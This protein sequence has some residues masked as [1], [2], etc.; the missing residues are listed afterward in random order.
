ME[1]IGNQFFN[2]LQKRELGRQACLRAGCTHFMSMDT[3]EFYLEDQLRR[4]MEEVERG[5]WDAT[6]CRM[7]ILFK[8]AVYEYW[9]PDEMN[10]VPL[11]CRC[12]PE[13]PLRLAEPYPV[14]LDPTRRVANA[15]R[16]ALLPRELVEMYHMSFVR[17][18]MALKL[19]NTS[20][21]A[22]LEHAR[23]FLARFATWRPEDGPIHPHPVIGRL[24]TEIRRLPNHFGVDLDLLCA[25]CCASGRLWRCAR[26][27]SARYCSR[28]CQRAHW[29]VHKAHPSLF[30]SLSPL[31]LLTQCAAR[32]PREEP[33]P[34]RRRNLT[35][36]RNRQKPIGRLALTRTLPPPRARRRHPRR[37]RGY[38]Y[39]RTARGSRHT[40]GA[41]ESATSR[42]RRGGPAGAGA[43]DG[44]KGK[45]GA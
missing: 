6:A 34:N 30:D 20:N 28:R 8:E 19:Q 33:T 36:W 23:E 39:Y 40:G 24:F 42:R 27:Q 35:T 2:E 32:M 31:H 21:R 5:Q 18:H 45:T 26:C 12:R 14:L 16:F 15:P 44:R 41:S 22:N 1:A 4:A 43:A 3:D 10:A 38:L 13:S 9:P 25:L 7:R 37:K 29:P 17:R 11:I